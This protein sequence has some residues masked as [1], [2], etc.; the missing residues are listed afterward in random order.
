MTLEQTILRIRPADAQAKARAW[1]HWDSIAKPLR[2]LGL[3][4]EAVVQLAGIQHTPDVCI[5]RRRVVVMCADN[6]I[7]AQGVTQSEQH[8]TAVVTE[9]IAHHNS[10]VCRMAASLGAEVVPVDVGVAEQLHADGIVSRKIAH[11]TQDFTKTRAMTRAQ[12]VQAVEVGIEMAE[13]AK[14]DGINLLAAGEMGIGNTTTSAAVAAVLLN[15][16]PQTVTGRG[17]GLSGEGLKKKIQVIRDGIALHQPDPEDVLDV[18]SAV[19]G[20]DLCAMCGLYLG[21]A[22]AGIGVVLDGIISCVAALCAC[23]MCPAAADYLIASHQSAEPAGKLLLDAMDKKPVIMANMALGEGTGAVAAWP[24]FDLAL[25]V[26][27][28]MCTFDQTDIGVYV[29]LK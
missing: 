5:D 28:E 10:S 27:R 11:G 19:G 17:S 29:P 2:S 26:Y 18:L 20:F 23:R 3:L 12:A 15:V 22:A 9:N 8:V 1:K 16:E 6:G 4:E 14:A 21:A 13:R 25:T 7:V 24:L